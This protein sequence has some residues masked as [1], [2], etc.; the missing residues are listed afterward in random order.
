MCRILNSCFLTAWLALH[1]CHANRPS[2]ACAS[3]PAV[4]QM[5]GTQQDPSYAEVAKLG[6]GSGDHL[7]PGTFQVGMCA[8]CWV[9]AGWLACC[10]VP[11][12]EPCG[13]SWAERRSVRSVV[14]RGEA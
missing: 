2:L 4:Y 8:G 10:G 6:Y 11:R 7:F 3:T 13:R 12:Q 14:W 9:A 5:E 1:I